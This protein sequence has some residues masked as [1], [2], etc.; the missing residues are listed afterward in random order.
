MG[1]HWAGVMMGHL[2]IAL[3]NI[4][5][6][7]FYFILTFLTPYKQYL[8]ELFNSLDIALVLFVEEAIVLYKVTNYKHISLYSISYLVI[9]LAPD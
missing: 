6:L 8:L 4:F 5:F 3:H 7:H 2:S 9:D 1:W